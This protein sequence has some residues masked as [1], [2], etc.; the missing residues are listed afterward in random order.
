MPKA[1]ARGAAAQPN[2]RSSVLRADGRQTENARSNR[3][4]TTVAT[5]TGRTV[6]S[7]LPPCD[8]P[9]ATRAIQ[10]CPDDLS[11]AELARAVPAGSRRI[12]SQREALRTGLA[13]PELADVRADFRANLTAWWRLHVLHMS[14]GGQDR[15]P[16]GTT[17][18]TRA[19]VCVLAGFG[20]S[21]YKV[22]R[23]WWE[24][25][26][27]VAIARPGRTPMLR[28]VALVRPGD[29]NE[30]QV[31]VICC[32][33]KKRPISSPRSGQAISRPLTCSGSE[34]VLP[35]R[36]AKPAEKPGS[37]TIRPAALR[38]WPL[39]GVSDGWWAHLTGPFAVAG[40]NSTEL[41]WAIDHEPGGRARRERLANV[42]HP[43]GW[44]RW[45]LAPWRAPDGRP[46]PSPAQEAERRKEAA[47][48]ELARQRAE[49]AQLE[50]GRAADVAG[51]ADE[52]RR[53]LAAR[54]GQ[55]ARD[56]ATHQVSRGG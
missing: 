23:A 31:L 41:L 2:T 33:R 34:Q 38:A 26:G 32:P 1:P 37:G 49:R 35:T 55:V 16:A 13:C 45:R 12:R 7:P 22:C 42:V 48:A 5:V 15:P 30:R 18:P 40:W 28:P 51:K 56:L 24:A 19:R 11:R 20:V 10:S 3:K 4:S 6:R 8:T 14:W 9:P 50:A 29:H 47:R 27:Y 43:V 52:I 17:Q 46:L 21:T 53:M 36:E 44:L 25:R 39:R 54:G